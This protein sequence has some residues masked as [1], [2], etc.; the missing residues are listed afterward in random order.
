ML[1]GMG[2]GGNASVDATPT[3]VWGDFSYGENEEYR[4]LLRTGMPTPCP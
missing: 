3:K 4:T 1:L 2:M